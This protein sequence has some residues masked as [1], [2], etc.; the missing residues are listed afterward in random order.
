M[1]YLRMNG[2]TAVIFAISLLLGGV[3]I[4]LRSSYQFL[5]GK[6]LAENLYEFMPALGVGIIAIGLFGAAISGILRTA[7]AAGDEIYARN[8]KNKKQ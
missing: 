6:P 7:K 4:G 3:V 5:F 8:Q 2:I 1:F